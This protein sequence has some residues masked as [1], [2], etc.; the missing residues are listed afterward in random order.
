MV[1]NPKD[2]LAVVKAVR[3]HKRIFQHRDQQQASEANR[4]RQRAVRRDRNHGDSR[5]SPHVVHLKRRLLRASRSADLKSGAK[6]GGPGLGA[7][8]RSGAEDSLE[9]RSLLQLVPDAELWRRPG[10]GHRDSRRRYGPLRVEAWEAPGGDGRRGNLLLQRRP[11]HAGHGSADH[12]VSEGDRNVHGGIAGLSG[13]HG[14]RGR[15]A[16]GHRRQARGGEIRHRERAGVLAEQEVQQSPGRQNRRHQ[17][18]RRAP[19]EE[20]ARL[21][22]HAPEGGRERGGGLLSTM[23]CF[24]GNYAYRTHSRVVWDEKWTLPA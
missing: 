7:L 11:R 19:P 24:M 6:P 16:A 10:D 20:L 12:R 23:A 3:D 21:H 13:R 5:Y 18:Q 14:L 1:H 17:A 9:P 2:G 22:P 8:A 4:R 15:G